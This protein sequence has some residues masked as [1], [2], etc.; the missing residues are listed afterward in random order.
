MKPEPESALPQGM[1]T[2]SHGKSQSPSVPVI[3]CADSV[4][5]FSTSV[6]VSRRPMRALAADCTTATAPV[7][8][9]AAMLVPVSGT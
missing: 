1:K 7:R 8:W 6:G 2:S 9:G 4:I 3:G 5:T